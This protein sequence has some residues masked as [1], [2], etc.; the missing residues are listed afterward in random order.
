[1]KKF[2]RSFTLFE[3]IILAFLA[4]C[5]VAVKP[6]V[7]AL[8]HLVTGPL[9]IPGGSLAGGLYMLFVILGAALVDK[10]GAATLVCLIQSIMVMVT[11]VYG[12][13]GAA[14]LFTYVLPGLLADLYWIL[15]RTSAYGKLPC[16]FGCII[17][18]ITGVLLVNIV[19]F[20]L[21]AVPL[22]FSAA[23]AAFSGGLGG[24]IAWNLAKAIKKEKVME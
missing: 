7:V 23:L 15:S 11:G 9:L 8:T 2:F 19:F 20:R 22:L 3:L 18:N 4:A 21:P 10:R 14:S 16:F 13:H 24:L 6:L 5:G 12:T 1:M 17:A